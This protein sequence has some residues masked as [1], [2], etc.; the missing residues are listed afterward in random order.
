[1]RV[2]L[3]YFYLIDDFSKYKY[4]DDE[5]PAVCLREVHHCRLHRDWHCVVVL[6][7]QA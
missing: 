3:I 5:E 6:L 1:M 2:P 4:D 7:C